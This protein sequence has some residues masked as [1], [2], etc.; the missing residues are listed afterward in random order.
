MYNIEI[1]PP[2]KKTGLYLNYNES[3]TVND[4]FV[5]IRPCIHKCKILEIRYSQQGG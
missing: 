1:I 5:N 3:Q 2:W 4:A